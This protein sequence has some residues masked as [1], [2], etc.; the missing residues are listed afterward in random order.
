MLCPKCGTENDADARFCK[1]CGSMLEKTLTEEFSVAAK[2]LV[3]KIEDLIK[4]GNVTHIIIK[5]EQGKTLL[6]LPATVFVVGAI[7][8]PWMA[9]L[10][11]IAALATKC[12]V[13]VERQAK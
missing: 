10:G 7:L 3:S 11:A 9:A 6:E 8:A 1:K 2:D 12:K 5:N 13:V 4:D